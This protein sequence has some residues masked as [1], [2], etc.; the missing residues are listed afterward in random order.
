MRTIAIN[1]SKKYN[2]LIGEN[3]LAKSGEYILE[4]VKKPCT[5]V[6][7]TDDN[8][9]RLYAATVSASLEQSGFKVCRFVFPHGEASKNVTVLSRLWEYMA[10][11]KVTRGDIIVALGGGVVGDLSG[12]AAASYLRGIRFVQIPT[13]LLAMVDSSVGGKTAVDL[14]EGKNLV[15]AFWQPELVL[16]DHTTLATLEPK[17]YIDGWAEIIKYGFIGDEELLEKLKGAA[18]DEIEEIIA[19]SINDKRRLVE[20]DEYDK[21]SRQLLN[22]GH[23][24]GHAIE[25]C[26]DF[27]ISH[28][29]AVAMGM[30]LVT[31]AAVKR[32]ICG[33]EVLA[34]MREL[35]RKYGLEQQC[36]YSAAEIYQNALVDKKRISDTLTLVVPVKIGQSVLQK[37]AITDLAEFIKDGINYA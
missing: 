16:C 7:V 13:T 36:P 31:Q 34:L 18:K 5:A 24:L 2:V 37:I 23:T 3:L 30:L 12:F 15:G 9:E 28:G 22:L 4:A 20:A 10:E 14:N 33:Q 6:I 11:Q 27:Q 8:V 17:Y 26:S 1:A 25:K 19:C 32:E 21:G 35:T 29:Q